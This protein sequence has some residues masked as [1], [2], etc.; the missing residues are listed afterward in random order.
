MSEKENFNLDEWRKNAFERMSTGQPKIVV[1]PSADVKRIR[2]KWDKWR[3][4]PTPVPNVKNPIKYQRLF[5]SK[6]TKPII[7]KA[8]K[9]IQNGKKTLNEN[10]LKSFAIKWAES[11]EHE[12]MYHKSFPRIAAQ[13]GDERLIDAVTD[14]VNACWNEGLSYGTAFEL[15]FDVFSEE[16][17][18]ALKAADDDGL[19]VKHLQIYVKYRNFSAN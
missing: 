12:E 2:E 16:F 7:E 8:E 18:Q 13:I 4:N 1:Q 11:Y 9:A 6:I 3:Q 5:S 17:I 19:L 14:V 10:I 15:R